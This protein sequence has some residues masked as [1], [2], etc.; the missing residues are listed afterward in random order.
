MGTVVV[1]VHGLWLNG[2]ESAL[3]RRRLA[4]H[5]GCRTLAFRYS[6]VRADVAANARSLATF[7]AGTPADTLHLVGHSLGGLIILK[8]FESVLPVDERIEDGRVLPPGR[9]VLLGSPVRGSRAAQRLARVPLG[10]RV[11]GLT[12]GQVL[13][14]T[15][16]RRWERARQ[17]GVIA[18]DVP[19]GLGR[20]VAP[21]SAPNDGTVLVA[22]TEIEGATAHLTVR[23][24]HTGM[25]YSAAVARNT[26]TFLATGRF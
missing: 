4:R 5:L 3:L 13:L 25:V 19:V 17:L 6:S 12:A 21:F 7:L 20:L 9:V 14:A 1:Y 23:T 2:W 18:G 8:Y 24:N 26:A 11:M 22:E 10:Q 16:E 15:R